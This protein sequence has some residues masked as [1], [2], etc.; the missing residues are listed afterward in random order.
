MAKRPDVT[1]HIQ[2]L[3]V[4]PNSVEWTAPGD[5]IDEDLVANLVMV[6]AGDLESL[7]T[8][9][10]DGLEAPDDCLW[11]VLRT[12]YV[13]LISNYLLKSELMWDHT[14]A[15]ILQ[16]LELALEKSPSIPQAMYVHSLT[17][18]YFIHLRPPALQS[19]WPSSA[20]AHSKMSLV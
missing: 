16:I 3:L 9:H 4:H 14:A 12:Q 15:F 6:I 2:R 10:W 11:L 13:S 5:E 19:F 18:A 8:F 7:H 20:L 17:L 1:Q